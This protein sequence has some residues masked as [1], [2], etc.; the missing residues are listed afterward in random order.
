MTESV[1]EMFPAAK[2]E[3]FT[4]V[5]FLSG[6][7]VPANCVKLHESTLVAEVPILL[8]T[9]S[10]LISCQFPVVAVLVTSSM[11]LMVVLS[12]NSIPIGLTAIL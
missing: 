1:P 7:V 12:F 4:I 3:S 10:P 2:Q 6:D 8:I 11:P 5:P 9:F